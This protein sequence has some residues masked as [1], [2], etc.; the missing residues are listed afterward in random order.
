MNGHCTGYY[1]FER[2]GGCTEG[3]DDCADND[4]T[5]DIYDCRD[6]CLSMDECNAFAM[7]LSFSTYTQCLIYFGC[8]EDVG[9]TM[10]E[11]Q[12]FMRECNYRRILKGVIFF[13]TKR[14]QM[15]PFGSDISI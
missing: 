5:G 2:H 15:G 11:L 9:S 7:T 10:W 8:N 12:Y 14:S 4:W 6:K 3:I 13:S 1:H